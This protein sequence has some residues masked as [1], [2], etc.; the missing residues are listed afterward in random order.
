MLINYK[1]NLHEKNY[2]IETTKWKKDH[3]WVKKL[4]ILNTWYAHKTI[5]PTIFYVALI[6]SEYSSFAGHFLWLTDFFTWD[7]LPVQNKFV[8]FTWA[9]NNSHSR[10]GFNFSFSGRS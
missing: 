7:F 2:T 3:W 6:M 9:R 4:K 8:K 1:L 5:S 10:V